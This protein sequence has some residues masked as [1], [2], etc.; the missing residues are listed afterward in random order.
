MTYA[1]W[2]RAILARFP[3][4]EFIDETDGVTARANDADC[5]WWI[6]SATAEEEDH[7]ISEAA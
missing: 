6:A 2:K 1:Q 4:A 3:A 7:F 5:G